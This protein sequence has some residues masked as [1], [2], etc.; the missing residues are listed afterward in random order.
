[1]FE[2]KQ[3]QFQKKPKYS[4]NIIRYALLLRYTSL[5]F[6]SLGL[7]ITFIIFLEENYGGRNRMC[8]TKILV[9]VP[10]S[11]VEVIAQQLAC[12]RNNRR[13]GL[14]GSVTKDK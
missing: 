10:G 11:Q 4:K 7:S 14:T 6:D 9:R 13:K 5:P 3:I 1:M 12:T 8:S 2:L